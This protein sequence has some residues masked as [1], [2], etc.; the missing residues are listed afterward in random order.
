MVLTVYEL[1][2]FNCRS[3]TKQWGR[4]MGCII[5]SPHWLRT[6]QR[7]LVGRVNYIHASAWGFRHCSFRQIRHQSY[8]GKYLLIINQLRYIC[9]ILPQEIIN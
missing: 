6:C 8:K 7:S 1:R 3:E 9:F 4:L 2:N 5:Y